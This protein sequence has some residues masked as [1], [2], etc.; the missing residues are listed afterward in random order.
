MTNDRFIELSHTECEDVNGGIFGLL[1][2][3]VLMPAKFVAPVIVATVFVVG[4]Y[5]GFNRN[6][7]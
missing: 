6:I 5:N 3:P 4:V 2:A 1:L 7:N